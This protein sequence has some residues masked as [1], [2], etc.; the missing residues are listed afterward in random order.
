MES[1][2]NSKP[3]NSKTAYLVQNNGQFMML[4]PKGNA[5]LYPGAQAVVM[6]PI[7]DED[8]AHW[9]KLGCKYSEIPYEKA[10]ELLDN[11]SALGVKG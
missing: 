4:Y 9:E 2:S 8:K 6:E 10:L 5:F 11:S 1:K 3:T 7:T